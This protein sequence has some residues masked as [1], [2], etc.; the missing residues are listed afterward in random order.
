MSYP[1]FNPNLPI[2]LPDWQGNP[3][4][5]EGRYRN[6]G[7]PSERSMR[8][9]M[10]WQSG[11]RPQKAE[12]KA[13]TWRMDVRDGDDFFKNDAD[14]LVWLGHASFLIRLG[15]KLLL[16][17]PVLG[18]VG[19]LK[20]RSPLPFSVDR[21]KNIDYILLSHNHRDHADLPS[22]KQICKQNPQTP[23]LT[24]LRISTLIGKL[25]QQNLIQEA[26]WWQ[27][28]DTGDSGLEITYLPAKHWNRRGL[29]DLNEML[30]GAFM[31]RYKGKS[32]FFGADSGYD[33]HF[34]TLGAHFPKPD[35]CLLGIGAYSP[36]W[37]MNTSHTNPEE[38]VQAFHDL[39]GSRLLPMHYGTFDLSDEPF[40]EPFRWMKGLESSVQGGL[41]L[42]IPGEVV[43]L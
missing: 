22:F 10:R 27:Q 28:Y 18:N 6:L 40:G 29:F 36:Q 21:L 20:R 31:I 43:P 26:G 5:A 32:V 9:V 2:I 37:F 38:T 30:W 15:G 41:C 1:T 33:A 25:T 13:D 12:K 14:G 7:G 17:D 4:S 34:K 19:P 39:G 8:E 3:L 24:G 11:A 16:I 42:A 23:I 35:L